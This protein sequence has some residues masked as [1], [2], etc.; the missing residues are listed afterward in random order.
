MEINLKD[1]KEGKN[2][3]DFGRQKGELLEIEN[4]NFKV[5]YFNV[6]GEIKKSRLEYFLN[7]NVKSKMVFECARCLENFEKDLEEKGFYHI[8]LGK[9]RLLNKKEAE[10]EED[11]INT[12]YLEEPVLN[13]IGIV[14]ELILLSIPMKPLC[15]EDCKGLCPVC[16]KNKNKE[17]C[18]C[19]T[20][21]KSP[22]SRIKEIFN[23]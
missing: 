11:D 13:L 9:D 7:I 6:Y 15:K 16:G 18:N 17:N 8:K 23:K 2:D 10:I 12:I 4:E 3:F 19:E 21:E 5:K 22:L 20:Q 14:R 1:L